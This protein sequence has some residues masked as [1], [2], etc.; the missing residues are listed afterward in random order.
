M[1]SCMTGVDPTKVIPWM[2]GCSNM[3]LT[4]VLPPWTMF[5]TPGGKPASSTSSVILVWLKGTSLEGFTM[6]VLPVATA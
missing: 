1:T 3:P 6:T 2:S 5:Q 4:T